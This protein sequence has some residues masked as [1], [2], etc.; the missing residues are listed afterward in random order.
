MPRQTHPSYEDSKVT[1]RV[2]VSRLQMNPLS[3]PVKETAASALVVDRPAQRTSDEASLTL[4]E[5]TT[6]QCDALNLKPRRGSS[7]P[8]SS[9]ARLGR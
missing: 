8:V 7:S 4:I 5:T 1:K 3:A 9:L 2:T 6:N